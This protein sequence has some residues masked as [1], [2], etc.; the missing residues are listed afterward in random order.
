ME[1][2]DRKEHSFI[3]L[4]HKDIKYSDQMGLE[5]STIKSPRKR[6]TEWEQL[7]WVKR[8]SL[9]KETNNRAL[10]EM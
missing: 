5:C 4:L 3:K 7:G 1:T 9:E 8:T 10:R 2:D 6:A